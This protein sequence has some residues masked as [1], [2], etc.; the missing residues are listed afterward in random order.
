MR[1]GVFYSPRFLKG[2]YNRHYIDLWVGI[3]LVY[4][5][6]TFLGLGLLWS[7]FVKDQVFPW[8]ENHS[9]FGL[10]VVLWFSTGRYR[11]CFLAH[12]GLE[13]CMVQWTVSLRKFL[14]MW[15]VLREKDCR[16]HLELEYLSSKKAQDPLFGLGTDF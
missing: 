14:F 6:L 10:S 3:Q 11:I 8:L 4:K 12:Q 15:S 9:P 5:S 2:F 1:E 7:G 13:P 16:P